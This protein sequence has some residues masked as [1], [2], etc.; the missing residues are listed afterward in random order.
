MKKDYFKDSEELV[1]FLGGKE[2]I[3]KVFHCT[4]RLRFYLKDNSLIEESNIKKLSEVKGIN[5]N[6]EQLQIIVGNDV[7]DMYKALI[8][9]GL[10]NDDVVVNKKQSGGIISRVIES[11]TGCMTPM[12]PALTA[13]GMIKVILTLITAFNLVDNTSSTYKVVEFIG[14]VVFYFMPFLVAANA[15][16]VFG[17][18]QSLALFIAG[19]FLHPNFIAMIGSEESISFIGLQVTKFSY[20][21]SV[22]PVILM[23]W[24]MSYIEKFV[25]KIIPRMLKII[26][27]PTLVMLISAPIAIIAVGPLGGIIGNGLALVIDFLSAKL[28]F[29]IVGILA[30]LFPFIVM[31]GMHH[32]LTPIGLNAIA[33]GGAD[34]LIFVSQVCSN[35][36]QSGACFGVALRTKNSEMRQLASSAG[37]SALMGI[38]E[39]ALYGITLKLKRPVIAAAIAA[40]IGGIFGGIVQVSLYVAQNSI[41]AIPAFIGEVGMM[42]LIYGVIMI[43]VSFFGAFL[44]TLIIGFKDEET[45]YIN[46]ELESLETKEV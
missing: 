17:V 5:W 31:T 42:N 8:S 41:M 40:G 2:N 10:P 4:T 38:T 39:P 14:D 25:D 32:A 9:L 33:T 3:I 29:I 18:N 7:G 23:V 22:I 45:E 13:A 30:A 21:Y 44:L 46:K 6:K 27:V 12:I 15:S 34:K 26:L 20:P 35:I 1:K 19:T 43:A 28:G 11:I 36:A 37:V 16:K 24:I